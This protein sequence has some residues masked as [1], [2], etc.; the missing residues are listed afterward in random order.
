MKFLK[1]LFI[2]FC[3]YAKNTFGN[4]IEELPIDTIALEEVEISANK[5][6]NFTTG[7]K[8]ERVA[9]SIKEKYNNSNLSE[10][11][12]QLSPISVKSYGM[13]GLSNISLR[14]MG[15]KHTAILWNGINL[16]NSMNGGFDMNSMPSFIIDDIN[17]QYGGS[18]ALFGSGSIGGIVHINNTVKFNNALELEYNQKVGSFDNYFEGFKFNYSNNRFSSSTRVYHMYGKNDFTFKNYQQFGDPEVKQK[19]SAS[20]QYGIL[21]SNAFKIKD[22]QTISTNIWAQYHYL[23]IPAMITNTLSE[24]NQSTDLLR[25]TTMWNRNGEISSWYARAYFNY[26]SQTYKN[27]TIDLIAQLDNQSII[28]EIENKT[29]IGDNF[30][31]NIGLN[32]TYQEA[33]T[34]NYSDSKIRNQTALYSSLKYFNNSFAAVLSVREELVD[35]EFTPF[36]FS[37]SSRYNFIKYLTVNANVSKTFNLPSFNDLYWV[38]G[39]NPDLKSENGWSEDLGFNFNYPIS[40]HLISVDASIFNINLNNNIIWI[41]SSGSE[42]S[43]ENVEKLW[44]RGL[45]SNLKYLYQNNNW[46]IGLNLMCSYTKST[47]EESENTDKSSVGKQLL[48]I[49]IYKSNIGFNASYKN[50]QLAYIHNFVGKRYITK[51]NS[52]SI[53]PYTVG[54]LSIG[55]KLNFKSSFINIQFKVNNIW[56]EIYEVMAFYAMPTRYYS[57]NLTYNFNKPN[58]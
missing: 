11:L 28:G 38:P 35:N 55:S 52:G 37:V 48:Y 34:S 3:L 10:L 51:D 22:N 1:I 13:A 30:L 7:A 12:A 23:E 45:E 42:W 50:L 27:P 21:Q 58:N 4:D 24:Q 39:G 26:E 16:Q 29:A 56:N 46:T 40:N 41:P 31:L 32:N 19:N 2:F 14:G 53:D 9:S 49:P 20:T 33:L 17:I 43:A 47:Y 57:I 18:G 44:S 36:T 8:V 54:D 25:I 6:V 15:T 5:L